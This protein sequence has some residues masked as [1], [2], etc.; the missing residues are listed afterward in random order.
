M[1]EALIP[2]T[3]IGSRLPSF[4][5]V[6]CVGALTQKKSVTV[7]AEIAVAIRNV[8]AVKASSKCLDIPQ[9]G[10]GWQS[11]KQERGQCRSDSI[12]RKKPRTPRLQFRGGT[13]WAAFDSAIAWVDIVRTTAS[14]SM[15]ASVPALFVTWGD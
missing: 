2:A 15:G 14:R 5:R 6:S 10:E 4:G 11:W 9:N 3:S 8:A 12:R 7:F 13:A 1:V